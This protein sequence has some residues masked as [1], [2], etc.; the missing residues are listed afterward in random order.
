MSQES[1]AAVNYDLGSG[2]RRGLPDKITQ[3]PQKLS[4]NDLEFL[5]INY[6]LS[7]TD[8]E[9]IPGYEN[10]EVTQ[11][12]QETSLNIGVKDMDGLFSQLN[13]SKAILEPENESDLVR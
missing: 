8:I 13:I 11:T 1:D 10:F 5:W 9:A 3:T 6:N 2:R 7:V 12:E 4:F